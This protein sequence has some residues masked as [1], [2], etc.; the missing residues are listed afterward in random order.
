MITRT[1]CLLL[2][3]VLLA[4]CLPGYNHVACTPD[5]GG[6]IAGFFKGIWHGF[7]SPLSFVL[8]LFLWV[9]PYEIHNS[10]AWY[11]LGFGIGL[12]LLLVAS[13]LMF[14]FLMIGGTKEEQN[15]N[16]RRRPD[17]RGG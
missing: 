2:L 12:V 4:G 3:V 16:K 9:C 1:V 14:V 6:K 15:T 8:S 11:N 5:S 7:I 10:G 13:F 17:S